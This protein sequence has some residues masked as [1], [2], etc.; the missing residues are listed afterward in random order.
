MERDEDIDR[1]ISSHHT[2]HILLKGMFTLDQSLLQTASSRCGANWRNVRENV[3]MNLSVR[4]VKFFELLNLRGLQ[5]SCLFYGN[6]NDKRY[7]GFP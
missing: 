4:C 6:L 5:I 2:T 1:F 7:F 3:F